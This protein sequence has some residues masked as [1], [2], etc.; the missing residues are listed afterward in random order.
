MADDNPKRDTNPN[1]N[2]DK[3]PNDWVSGGIR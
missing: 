3:D 1:T 2:F